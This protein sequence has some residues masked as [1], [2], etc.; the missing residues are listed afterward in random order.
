MKPLQAEETRMHY[1]ASNLRLHCLPNAILRF[2]R[3][4]WVN[5]HLDNLFFCTTPTPTPKI[6]L[7][8]CFPGARK[9][10]LIVKVGDPVSSYR[11]T[12]IVRVSD[13]YKNYHE[14]KIIIQ[15]RDSLYW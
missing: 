12:L 5:C 13:L 9:S 8:Y 6:P 10:Y 4:K 7:I 11:T 1:A 3:L 2:S 15:V 14:F